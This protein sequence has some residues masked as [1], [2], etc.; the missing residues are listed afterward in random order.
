MSELV[1][2]LNTEFPRGTDDDGLDILSI[3]P[4]SFQNRN[5]KAQVL[6]VPVGALAMTSRPSRMAG[7]VL[8]CTG[9]GAANPMRSIARSKA[10]LSDNFS[11]VTAGITDWFIEADFLP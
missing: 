3:L 1:G 5:A 10:G 8:A 7:M 4:E 9:V 2:N 6:P 11:K